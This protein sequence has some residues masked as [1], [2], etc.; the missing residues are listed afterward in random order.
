MLERIAAHPLLQ[1]GP[2]ARA[3]DVGCGAGRSTAALMSLAR[4]VVGLEPAPAMLAHWRDVARAAMFVVGRAEALPFADGSFDVATAAGA[5]NYTDPDRALPELS[6]VLADTGVLVIYDFSSGRRSRD[7]PAL[8]AWFEAFERR[9]FYPPGY[10]LDV[11]ALDYGRA[12]LQLASFETFEVEV[13]LSFE[14]YVAYAMSEA[15]VETAIASGVP[16]LELREWC[17]QSL[18]PVFAGRSLMVAFD[19]YAA[20]VVT[21]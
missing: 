4:S 3:L 5:L 10:A 21:G 7:A 20:Y 9:Y 16:E 19:A 2:G 15:N 6:R 12:G 14:A 1:N 13:L 18:A 11:R 8:D 17:V